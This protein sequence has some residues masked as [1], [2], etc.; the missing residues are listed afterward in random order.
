M[1]S[2]PCTCPTRPTH[3][4]S[5]ATGSISWPIAWAGSHSN[6]RFSAEQRQTSFPMPHVKA[7]IAGRLS[8]ELPSDSFQ[9][10]APRPVC[11]AARQ[12]P[13]NLFKLG[14]RFRHRPAD[15]APANVDTVRVP[16]RCAW[17]MAFSSPRTCSGFQARCSNSQ[18][19]NGN[20]RPFQFAGP[21]APAGPNPRRIGHVKN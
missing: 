17:S 8:Q 5:C 18:R 7:D 21:T 3:F 19:R 20:A 6:P 10:S 12:R 11:R 14:D 9:S 16:N 2:L 15:S 4:F 1:A 13:K